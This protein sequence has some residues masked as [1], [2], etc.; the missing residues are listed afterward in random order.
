MIVRMDH[1]AFAVNDLEKAIEHAKLFGGKY[2]FTQEVEKDGYKVAGMAIGEMVLTLMTPTREDSWVR[3]YIDKNG[4]GLN[5]LGIEVE[6]VIIPKRPFEKW[7]RE[8][9]A[10][11]PVTIAEPERT[12]AVCHTYGSA[13]WL[14]T[15]CD[16][17]ADDR[18]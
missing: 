15:A 4:E 8:Q 6:A 17:C 9:A 2:L 13:W 5:H 7:Y 10:R 1:I 12:R 3:K 18:P 16:R 11:V 14:E